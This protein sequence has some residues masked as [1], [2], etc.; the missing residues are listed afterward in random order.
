MMGATS[1]VAIARKIT[2]LSAAITSLQTIADEISGIS[3]SNVTSAGDRKWAGNIYS[4]KY[5]K[6]VEDTGKKQTTA[7]NELNKT[8]SD[9]QTTIIQLEN[10]LGAIG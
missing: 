1:K 7:V 4:Q 5:L 10:Q 2:K 6:R 9:Y 8:I 3:L